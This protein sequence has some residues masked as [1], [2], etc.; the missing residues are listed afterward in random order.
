MMRAILLALLALCSTVA[1]VADEIETAL[2]AAMAAHKSGDLAATQKSVAE[3]NRLLNEKAASG[4][5]EALPKQIGIWAA[6]KL[7]TQTLE[8]A[9]G[10]TSLRRAYRHGA[11]EKGEERRGTVV[12]TVDSPLMEKVG[13][14]LANPQIGALLGAKPVKV[15]S[16]P[17]VHIEKQ[18]LIQFIVNKRYLVAIEG[19]KLKSSELMEI[20][21]GV[22]TEVLK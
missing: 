6:G 16:H 9:G 17:A 15:G 5:G 10:G 11:K 7:E 20:A 3:A 4:L 13:S 21:S 2:Q 12:I 1:A 22:K 14:F 19:K 18:G 8:G